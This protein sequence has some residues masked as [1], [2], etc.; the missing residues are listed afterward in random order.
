MSPTGVITIVAVIPQLRHAR[1]TIGVI[2]SLAMSHTLRI[3]G[4]YR[5]SAYAIT[6]VV[7]AVDSG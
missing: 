7:G 4:V 6:V 3:R 5:I 1:W 2:L